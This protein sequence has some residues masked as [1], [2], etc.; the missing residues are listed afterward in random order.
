MKL[1]K[2][3]AASAAAILLLSSCSV[4]KNTASSALSTGTSTGSALSSLYQIFKSSGSIDLSNVTN[5]I[6]LGKILTGASSLTDATSA[7]TDS[8]TSGLISGS[9]N[10]VNSSNAASVISALKSLSNVDTSAITAAA[11]AAAAGSATQLT[12]ST[13]GVSST[14]SSLNSIF[15]LLK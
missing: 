4:L 9:S 8:F 5:I 15:S 14:L 6:N 1:L 13:A 11:A 3:L 7:F 2:T 10:L 12:T